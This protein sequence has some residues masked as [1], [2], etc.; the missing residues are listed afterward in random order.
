MQIP[1]YIKTIKYEQ[2]L[3]IEQLMVNEK[4]EIYTYNS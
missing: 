4:E 1:Q 3:K 2:Y